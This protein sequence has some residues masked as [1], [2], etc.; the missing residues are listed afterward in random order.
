[1]K[2]LIENR[3]RIDL[4]SKLRL[5]GIMVR[6]NGLVWPLLMGSYYVTSAIAKTSYA[7]A[8]SLRAKNNLPGV[9]SS[10]ANKHIWENWNWSARGEEWTLSPEWKASVVKT[11]MGENLANRS[12]IL[13]IGPGAGRW[14]E[15]L[16]ERCH[17]LIGIDISETSVLECKRRFHEYEN[18]KFEVGNG[19]DLSSIESGSVDAVWSFDVFVHINKQQFK[20]YLIEL[21]R[22]LKPGGIGLIQ[23]GSTGGETGGWRSDV[24]T[25]DVNELL[26]SNGLVVEYQAQSWDDNGRKF[27]AGLY[28]DAIT[29]FHKSIGTINC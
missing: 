23:H 9:N 27:E 12:V 18:A 5:V 25:A 24:K 19:E 1:V 15:Y 20:S 11:F 8:A 29:I 10:L 22:V 7:T 17:R 4:L 16:L 14:T 3:T 2:D 28:Q 26:R 13:E 21:Q 6:D